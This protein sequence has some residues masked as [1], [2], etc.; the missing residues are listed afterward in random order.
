MCVL[1]LIY[2]CIVCILKDLNQSLTV[3]HIILKDTLYLVANSSALQK[4][5]GENSYSTQTRID[6]SRA[7][8]VP[9]L[10]LTFGE[11][12]AYSKFLGQPASCCHSTPTIRELVLIKSSC[13]SSL[14]G[15]FITIF[16]SQIQVASKIK[17]ALDGRSIC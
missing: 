3:H 12:V 14:Y 4:V 5:Q 7:R 8:T 1:A 16:C 2:I 10:I 11:S 9:F 15:T 17:D 6:R 13:I